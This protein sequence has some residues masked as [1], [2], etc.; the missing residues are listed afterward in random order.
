M[1]ESQKKAGERIQEVEEEIM[2]F[3]S[4]FSILFFASPD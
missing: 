2:A 4:S 1:F 3:P